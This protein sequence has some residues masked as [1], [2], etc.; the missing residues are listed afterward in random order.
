MMTTP[1]W[2]TDGGPFAEHPWVLV[3]APPD[4][5]PSSVRAVWEDQGYEVFVCEGPR[6]GH[7]CPLVR[8]QGCPVVDGA[9]LVV[10]GLPRDEATEALLAALA[11]RHPELPVIDSEL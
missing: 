8:D 9:H 10:N 11:Q 6:A 1:A 3:T 5:D 4:A 7:S 2:R